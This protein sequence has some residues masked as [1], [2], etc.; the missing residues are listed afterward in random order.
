MTDAYRQKLLNWLCTIGL[1][2]IA[3]V[4]MP[5]RYWFFDLPEL[6]SRILN[7]LELSSIAGPFAESFL[8]Y[9]LVAPIALLWHLGHFIETRPP[10]YRFIEFASRYALFVSLIATSIALHLLMLL[11][12][13]EYDSCD[14]L[15]DALFWECM[16]YPSPVLTIL[17]IAAM[18]LALALGVFKIGYSVWSLLRKLRLSYNLGG[19]A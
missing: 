8:Y 18:V 11:R 16:V 15:P 13:W 6:Q 7:P 3:T 14:E 2:L 5:L 19:V 12:V 1:V 4:L 17:W 10:R 9:V